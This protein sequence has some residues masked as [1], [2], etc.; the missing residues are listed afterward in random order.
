MKSKETINYNNSLIKSKLNKGPF[1]F[2]S[3]KKG[4][5]K[6]VYIQDIIYCKADNTYTIFHM[7]DNKN[8]LISHS[9]GEIEEFLQ[10]YVFFR[11]TRSYIVNPNHIE[12]INNQKKPYIKL[13]NET[14]IDVSKKQIKRIELFLNEKFK[15]FTNL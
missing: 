8:Y 6:K 11:I 14:K 7:V 5:K 2:L 10:Q 12:M 13:I 9:L 15:C 3:L 1:M 4:V